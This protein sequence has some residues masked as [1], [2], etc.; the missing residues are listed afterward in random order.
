MNNMY[1]SGYYPS[2]A[3]FD[4]NAPW[5][6][7]ELPERDIDITCSNTLSKS[8]SVHTDNYKIDGYDEFGYPC[9]DLSECNLNEVYEANNHYTAKQALDLAVEFAKKI[10]IYT[11]LDN[12]DHSALI[13]AAVEVFNACEGW[14]EDEL[15]IVVD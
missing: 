10:Y 3:E 6:K 5:N 9:L 2:G 12:K 11:T 7:Q 15:E 14:N 8:V 1:E 13:R 4:S